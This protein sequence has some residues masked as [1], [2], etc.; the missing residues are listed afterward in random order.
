MR[1]EDLT[2][3]KEWFPGY[4]KRFYSSNEEDQKNIILKEHHTFR[5]CENAEAIAKDLSLDENL[6]L[7]ATASALFHDVGRFPQYEKYKTF[8][9]GISVNHGILGAET[10]AREKILER[11]PVNEQALILQAVK[12]H[13]AF[14]LSHIQDGT[15]LL[16]LKIVRDADKLDIWDVFMGYYNMPEN[17][18][19]SAVGLG[20]PDTAEYSDKILARIFKKELAHLSDVKTLNDFKLLQLSWIFDLN[21]ETSFKMLTQRDYINRIASLLPDNIEIRNAV[22]FLHKFA[23]DRIKQ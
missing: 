23:E 19:A 12:F 7:L 3:F 22:A 8:R 10:L 5:V 21:L 15:A 14:A 16:L 2:F 17:E 1:Q 9:D 11:L 18:R 6:S 20:L 4:C 13:N